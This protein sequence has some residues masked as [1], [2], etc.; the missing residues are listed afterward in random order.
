MCGWEVI[1]VC[2]TFVCQI[3][4]GKKGRPVVLV[5]ACFL[6]EERLHALFKKIGTTNQQKTRACRRPPIKTHMCKPPGDPA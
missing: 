3:S 5:N 1:M 2:G 6:N 4:I